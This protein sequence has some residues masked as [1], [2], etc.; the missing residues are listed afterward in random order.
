MRDFPIVFS[1][2]MVLANHAG[3]KSMTRRVV[4]MDRLK[5]VFRETVVV[6]DRTGARF[7]RLYVG[8]DRIR[9]AVGGEG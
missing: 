2:P 7:I 6:L 3:R 9:Q 8:K 4:D 1:S 5:I